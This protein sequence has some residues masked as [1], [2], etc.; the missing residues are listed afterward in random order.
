M[1]R[2]KAFA[3]ALSVLF[4]AAPAAALDEVVTKRRAVIRDFTFESGEQVP[5]LELGVET[6]GRLNPARDNVILICHFLA[7]DSHAAGYYGP[8]RVREGWWNDLIGPGQAIDTDRFFVVCMDLPCNMKA[9]KDPMVVSGGPASLD[10][11][12][13]RAYGADWPTTTVRDMVRS[14]RAV[15]D[16]LGV[17]KLVAVTGPSLGGMLAWQF[18]IEYPDYVGLAIPVGAPVTFDEDDYGNVS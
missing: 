1:N 13:G 15:L 10:P 5:E 2:W 8:D 16:M 9:T 7:G 18:A 11:A 3:L 6:Y 12:T 14:Q 4:A 17:R